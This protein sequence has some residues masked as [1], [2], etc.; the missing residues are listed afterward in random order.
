MLSFFF[1]KADNQTCYKNY[2]I[3]RSPAIVPTTAPMLCSIIPL[4]GTV[5]STFSITCNPIN[6]RFGY[7]YCFTTQSKYFQIIN[8]FKTLL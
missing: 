1:S 5:L 6:P 3:Q 7:Q 4:N 2:T 8:V